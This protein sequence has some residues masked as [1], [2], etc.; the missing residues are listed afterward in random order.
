M[1]IG[2]FVTPWTVAF[3][4]PLSMWILQVKILEW[5]A[6]PSS[7]VSSQSRDPTGVSCIADRF[8]TS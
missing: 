4:A 8:F 5:I 7:R 1:P 6:M 2:L 3:W